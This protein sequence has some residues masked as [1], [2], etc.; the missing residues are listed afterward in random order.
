[1]LISKQLSIMKSHT[2]RLE[3][4]EKIKKL[5]IFWSGYFITC[6][7]ALGKYTYMNVFWYSHVFRK[8]GGPFVGTNSSVQPTIFFLCVWFFWT[9][10]VFFSLNMGGE[11]RKQEPKDCKAWKDCK[12]VWKILQKGKVTNYLERLKG[13]KPHIT[14]AFFN[15]WS[16]DRVTLH[17]V[18]VNLSEDFIAEVTGLPKE[19]IKFT[20]QTSISNAAFKKFPKTKDEEKQLEKRGDFFDL[21]QIKEIWRDVLGCIREYFI[22]DG[23]NKRVHKCHF[24]FLNHFRHKDCISFPFYLRFSLIH[25][26][27]AHKKKVS[28]PILHEGLILLIDE[29]CK[30]N[31]IASSPSKN[32][33][34]EGTK[35][36]KDNPDSRK[37][38]GPN[39]YPPAPQKLV[40]YGSESEKSA[41]QGNTISV[42]EDGTDAEYICS[43]TDGYSDSKGSKEKGIEDTISKSTSN[44]NRAENAGDQAMSRRNEK[45]IDT[46]DGVS[47]QKRKEGNAAMTDT[48]VKKTENHKRKGSGI[49]VESTGADLED[50]IEEENNNDNAGSPIHMN[51]DDVSV[52]TQRD[53]ILTFL[54]SA[55]HKADTMLKVDSWIYN[56]IMSLKKKVDILQQNQESICA[57]L[58]HLEGQMGDIPNNLRKYEQ[59]LNLLIKESGTKMEQVTASLCAAAANL[60]KRG[61]EESITAGPSKRTRQS[62]RKREMEAAAAS[63]ADT[64]LETAEIGKEM[65][66]LFP[67]LHHGV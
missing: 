43:T 40:D 44:Q 18:T 48:P 59:N 10:T 62:S 2:R 46:T 26:L 3:R 45:G 52:S 1:M 60:G 24:V 64:M 14:K 57:K 16:D 31:R 55:K 17:G 8:S 29:Y 42:S 15:N 19:G 5:M 37:E 13:C 41:S 25:S 6:L 32:K 20:K 38:K 30:N 11:P 12:E 9:E 35:V 7:F 53:T 23:R 56:E 51:E 65:A 21:H 34:K 27:E 22:L 67:G 61:R 63:A 50:Q 54:D 49:I 66:R 47:V 36:K 58:S 39:L 33:K 4:S 28:R